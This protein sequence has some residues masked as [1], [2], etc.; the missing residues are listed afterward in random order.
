MRALQFS[1]HG[2]P[3]VLK[4]TELPVPR[5]AAGEVLVRVR[6]AGLNPVDVGMVARPR[7]FISGLRLPAV[8]GWDVA[9]TVAMLGAGAEGFAVGDEVFGLS[10]FPVFV[11]GT[12]GE[13][14]TVPA[15]HLA[16]KPAQLSWEQAGALP[17]V[18]LTSLQA[19]DAVGGIQPGTR[20]LVEAA[21]GGV[22]HIAVQIAKAVGAYVVGT[23]SLRRHD[24]LRSFGVDEVIDYTATDDVFAETG[25]IDGV[26]LSASAA[27]VARAAKVVEPGG[28]LITIQHDITDEVAAITAERGVRHVDFLVAAD[29]A[30]IGRLARLVQEAKLKV[31]VAAAYPL[32]RAAEA[33]EQ[34]A[35]RHT[36]GK[37]V[38]LP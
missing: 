23:A 10:G 32:K 6:A 18:G 30:G 35:S 2:A 33:F 12:F 21:A 25:P 31:E 7:P 26:L 1:E 36:P 14:T 16:H 27:A 38:L 17:V 4:V 34:V 29:G 15:A 19:F 11:H 8:P 20:V 3:D 24:F 9:G 5:P 37:I 13:F 28:F 22:G